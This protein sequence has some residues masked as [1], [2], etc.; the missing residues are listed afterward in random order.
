MH[1]VW[2]QSIF[3]LHSV[4]RKF[5]CCIAMCSTVGNLFNLNGKKSNQDFVCLPGKISLFYRIREQTCIPWHWA[6]EASR[7]LPWKKTEYNCFGRCLWVSSPT[8]RLQKSTIMY[9][10]NTVFIVADC[11]C[12]FSVNKLSPWHTRATGHSESS[13]WSWV[14]GLKEMD[15][16]MVQP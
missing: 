9:F 14:G 12:C 4:Q 10:R 1:W 11:R 6:V 3:F 13:T 16:H 15:V 5:Y 7:L 2:R 8:D